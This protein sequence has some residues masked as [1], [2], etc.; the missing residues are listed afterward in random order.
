[1][2]I[3]QGFKTRYFN[4]SENV[5]YP[6]RHRKHYDINSNLKRIIDLTISAICGQYG[7][8]KNY[9]DILKKDSYKLNS[10]YKYN[11]IFQDYIAAVTN[12]NSTLTSREDLLDNL[13]NQLL[14]EF[15][16]DDYPELIDINLE[17]DDTTRLVLHCLDGSQQQEITK[18]LMEIFWDLY[19]KGIRIK[20]NQNIPDKTIE[21]WTEQYNDSLSTAYKKIEE[22]KNN[23]F[24]NLSTPFETDVVFAKKLLKKAHE[25]ACD[26][27]VL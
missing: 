15:P 11:T 7:Y 16:E 21:V 4:D 18:S 12:K 24:L 23:V 1:M 8:K 25:I 10:P 14:N 27:K 3:P 20:Y 5:L 2:V 17:W 9:G 19:S 6:H 22:I 13:L 26:D